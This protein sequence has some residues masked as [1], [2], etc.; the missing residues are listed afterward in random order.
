MGAGAGAAPQP[1]D[2]AQVADAVARFLALREFRARL[3][4]CLTAR[5]DALFELCDAI[6]CADHAVT[7]LVRLS[8]E[9]EFTR[10]HGALYDALKDGDIDEEAFAAL[11]AG[12]LPQLIDAGQGQAWTGEHDVTDYG[13]LESAIAGLPGE[14]AAQVREAC[15]RWRRLRFAIDAT[16]YPRPDAEC[17]PEREHVHH[18]ACRCDGARKTIPGW[19]YQFAAAVGHLRTAWT[20]LIDVERTA[21]AARTSQT[22]RQVKNLLRR[23]GAAGHAGG[24]APLVI[25]DAGYSAAG[26]TAALARQPVHLLVRLP[27]TS[28]FYGDPVTWPGR[29]GRPPRHGIPV[30]CH[31][32]PAAPNPEPDESLVL[33]GTAQ[34]GTVRVDAWRPV[35]PLVHADRGWF[36]DNRDG[37]PPVLRGTLLRVLVEHLPDGRPPRK[38][39]WLWHAGPAPLS[40][41]E[42]WRAYLARFDEE[43]TFRFLKGALGL[44]AAKVRT[45]AQADRWVRL[46]M[47]AYAQL[48]IAR[49]DTADL[50]RPWEKPP[51]P[52]RPLTPGR[53]RRGFPN[54]RRHIGTPA[55][56]AKPG[57]PGPGRPKGT[58]CGPAPRYPIPKKSRIKDKQDGPTETATG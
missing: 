48:L 37:E 21:K 42:L 45:P 52:D 17:S 8:L 31:N 4:A 28:V 40:L 1:P 5:P 25:L 50:R 55:H 15:A 24:G 54:I 10:G 29:N 12:T 32:D 26:L 7:S 14:Q 27:A 33:P 3:Y 6:L 30:T 22:A 44:T 39:M 43:H 57:R 47:A 56:V 51:D 16:P 11:L 18:D 35:H 41:D 19:E 13:L 49:T 23:L 46:V 34:Y 20:A 58:T 53:V 2:P 36:K 38:T 9:A